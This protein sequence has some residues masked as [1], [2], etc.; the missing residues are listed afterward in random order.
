MAILEIRDVRNTLGGNE[1]LKG[2]SFSIEEG[3]YV[4][5]IGPNGAGKSTLLRAVL[6]INPVS[7]GSIHVEGKPVDD[8]SRRKLARLLSFVPQAT[9]VPFPFL[10][11][12]FIE[13][14]LYSKVS[15][16]QIP[17]KEDLEA[18]E[19]AMELTDTTDFRSREITSLSGGE[20]Q[21]VFL[22][23]AIAQGS[24]IMLLDEPAT[25]LDPA[26]Q[27]AVY[28]I[29]SDANRRLGTTVLTVSHDINGAVEHSDRIVALKDGR[30]VFDGTPE[31]VSEGSRLEEIF[32]TAFCYA[33]HPVSGKRMILPGGGDE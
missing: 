26:H 21:R 24:K 14:S 30:V 11:E 12:E 15:P 25:Y 8:Y 3:S 29:V 31:E 1:I 28:G 17:T 22:A 23:A 19:H 5:V 32:G 10:V 27:K 16:F 4:T 33:N 20:R 6:G 13:M 2:V 18:V 9:A 7:Y